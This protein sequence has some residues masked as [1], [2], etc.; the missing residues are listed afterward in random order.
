MRKP[1]FQKKVGFKEPPLR[2]QGLASVH[3]AV[4][5]AVKRL[6]ANTPMDFRYGRRKKG[7]SKSPV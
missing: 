6:E 5:A 3:A 1:R 2:T 7:S 4:A